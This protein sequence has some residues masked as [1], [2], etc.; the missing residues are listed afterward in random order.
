VNYL[1][2]ALLVAVVTLTAGCTTVKGW[3]N[4]VDNT[5]ISERYNKEVRTPDDMKLQRES[6]EYRLPENTAQ[7]SPADH[8]T[9]PYSV[10][11]I[12]QGSW[13]NNDNPH[14]FKIM[15]EKPQQVEDFKAFLEKGAQGFIQSRGYKLLS[16]DGLTFRIEAVKS[17]ETGFWF[18]KKKQ[19]VERFVFDLKIGLEAH[20]RSGQAMVEPISL[21]VVQPKLAS[22][23]AK[24]H[25]KKQLAID[26]INQYSLELDYQFRVVVKK[27][28]SL[29]DVS[30]TI[31]KNSA[32]QTVITSQREIA[33]VYD[34]V[35][36]I[37]ETLGFKIVDEDDTL[38]IYT[39]AYNKDE[40]GF[41]KS[42]FASDY[43]DKIDLPAGQ[44]EAM[45][46]TSINGVHILFTDEEGKAL[47][48]EKIKQIY[49]L[50]IKIVNDEELEL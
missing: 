36:D 11:E 10:L 32:G 29:K 39:L 9:S 42:L 30:L 19:P 20:Q 34:E 27:L 18:W 16:K 21:K 48:E 26:M 17:N 15:L 41:W 2:P 8:I 5:P 28:R 43:A 14:P 50:M 40:T 7:A 13:I 3:F 1:K 12:L 44:Y 25:R 45:L 31:G 23:L 22:K 47:A 4:K 35:E 46:S 6:A 33:E 37:L 38:Y 24:P 49:D